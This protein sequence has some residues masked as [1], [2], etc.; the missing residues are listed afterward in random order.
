MYELLIVKR[1]SKDLAEIGQFLIDENGYIYS[2]GTKYK[3]C[4]NGSK[5][6]LDFLV[7]VGT[8]V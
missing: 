1:S 8:V 5:E 7:N 6:L 4:F 3:I 2:E